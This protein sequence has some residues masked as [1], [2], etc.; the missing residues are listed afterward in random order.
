MTVVY[1]NITDTI[2][3]VGTSVNVGLFD[4]FTPRVSGTISGLQLVLSSV[5]FGSLGN[6]N[7][8]LYADNKLNSCPGDLISTLLIIPDLAITTYPVVY[9]FGSVLLTSPYVEAGTRYWIG[10]SAAAGN[11]SVRWGFAK[12][13]TGLGV[14]NEYFDMG[15]IVIRNDH[16]GAYQMI[17]QVS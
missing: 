1:D 10:I 8:T 11:S 5:F 2:S 6:F 9:D 15:G 13:T 7:V 12:P 3:S 17:I 16:S 14:R 4:S